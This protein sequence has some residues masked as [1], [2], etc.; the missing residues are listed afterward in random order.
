[1]GKRME[2]VAVTLIGLLAGS[3][4]A[5]AETTLLLYTVCVSPITSGPGRSGG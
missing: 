3:E 1:M 4:A 2:C 5:R